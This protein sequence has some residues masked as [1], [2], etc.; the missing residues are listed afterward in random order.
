VKK[1]FYLLVF[2][3]AACTSEDSQETSQQ[4][5][6]EINYENCSDE[7]LLESLVDK[8]LQQEFSS[9]CLRLGEFEPS[10]KVEW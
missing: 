1:V 7:K 9:G 8:K 5:M 2:V 10:P 3:L 6:P 4:E